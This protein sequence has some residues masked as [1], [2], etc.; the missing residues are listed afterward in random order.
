MLYLKYELG[1]NDVLTYYMHHGKTYH[2]V[3]K[4]IYKPLIDLCEIAEVH[5]VGT[6]GKIFGDIDG[7]L[8]L[9]P[10]LLQH[11]LHLH[12]VGVPISCKITIYRI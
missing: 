2:I 3:Q 9:A 7:L 6:A 5:D 8:A 1:K 11:H 12:I 4:D 10:G